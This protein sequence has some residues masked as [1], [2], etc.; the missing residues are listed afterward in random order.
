MNT[1]RFATSVKNGKIVVSYYLNDIL[2]SEQETTNPVYL[3]LKYM[4]LFDSS[5]EIVHD[6][7]LTI[8]STPII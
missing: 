8:V 2:Q 1:R 5:S 7:N 3:I 4:E 6:I